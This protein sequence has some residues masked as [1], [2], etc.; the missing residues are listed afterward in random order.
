MMRSPIN[1]S[2]GPR[3]ENSWD[4]W[5]THRWVLSGYP[6]PFEDLGI[7]TEVKPWRGEELPIA[8]WTDDQVYAKI[9]DALNTRQMRCDVPLN[10]TSTSLITNAFMYTGDDHYR[11]WV[12]DYLEMWAERIQANGG[13]CPDNIGPNG[14]VGETLDGKWWGGYYGWRWP[15]GLHTIIEPLTIAAMNAVLLT[16]DL[17]YLDIPRSQIA[18]LIERGR[19]ENDQ[20]LI[21]Y[22]HTDDGWTSYRPL[23]P[24]HFAQLWYVS[25]SDEDRSYID[26]FP[27]VQTSWLDVRRA[28]AK[29]TTF[30]SAPGTVTWTV[31]IRTIRCAFLSRNM[32]K[33]CGAWTRWPTTTAI[34][35]SGM[36]TIG[37]I[38]TRCV[39]RRWFN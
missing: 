10:L 5:S 27:Q 30:I 11:Q 39:P 2:R 7:P 19:M 28:A 16:G 15:H 37:R 36:S 3:Y 9:L 23:E 20:L 18:Y 21:P 1:G 8:D 26:Q 17:G 34:R 38:S 29:A 25:Q 35:R 31:A 4:D 32:P 22:R 33:C 24:K 6:P 14:Q 12:V 13:I